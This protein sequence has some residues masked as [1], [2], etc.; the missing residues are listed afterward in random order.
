MAKYVVFKVNYGELKKQYLETVTA[1][2]IKEAQSRAF[3]KYH[4][5]VLAMKYQIGV[6]TEKAWNA[7]F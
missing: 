7:G 6:R 4:V 1:K 5:D 2:T 3:T